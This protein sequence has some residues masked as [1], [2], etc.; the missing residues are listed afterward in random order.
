MHS[1]HKSNKEEEETVLFYSYILLDVNK[2]V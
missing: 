1:L 2:S